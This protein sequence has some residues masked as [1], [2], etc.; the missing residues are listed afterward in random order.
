MMESFLKQENYIINIIVFN[1][2]FLSPT[3]QKSVD[4][5][6]WQ[7]FYYRPP[8]LVKIAKN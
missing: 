3:N 4:S 5:T 6:Y 7:L 2:R 8:G 1:T